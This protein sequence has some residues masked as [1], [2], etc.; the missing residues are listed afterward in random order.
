MRVI[1][2][3][4]IAALARTTSWPWMTV[5][6]LQG[7]LLQAFMDPPPPKKANITQEPWCWGER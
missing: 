5:P 4:D 2:K 7:R 6:V 1:S 3:G